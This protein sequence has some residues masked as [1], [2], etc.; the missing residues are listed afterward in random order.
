VARR[1]SSAPSPA[2]QRGRGKRRVA[3]RGEGPSGTAVDSGLRYL[4]ARAHSRLELRRKLA[5]KGYEADEVEA[6]LQRLA[7]LGYLDDAAFARG[8]V[9][10]R[11]ASRGPAAV[12]AE[13]ASKGI[14][15]E[16]VAAAL[17]GLGPEA[18]LEA[19]TRLAERLYAERP[20]PGYREMLDR[21][22]T[23][24]VRRGYSGSVVREACRAV[25][26]GAAGDTDL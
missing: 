17:A 26:A 11:S 2:P 24:L 4:A 15:R 3:T 9:R 22:G 19:A 21:I 14:D 6:A 7:E 23:K 10:R 1:S 5:R 12:A 13:L 8:L 25:L 16:G 18:Q 20:V